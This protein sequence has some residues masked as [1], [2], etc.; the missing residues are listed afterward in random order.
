M[1]NSIWFYII[2]GLA[3]STV[4]LGWLSLHNYTAKVEAESALVIAINANT[5][6]QK[7]LNLKDLSCKI[8]DSIS[9]ERTEEKQASDSVKDKEIASIDKLPVKIKA[10]LVTIPTNQASVQALS[11]EN[12]TV[13]IDNELPADLV[14][15]LSQSYNRAKE[16]T[17]DD[18]RQ[19]SSPSL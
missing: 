9:A 5:D 3:L 14:R 7:S 12:N 15:L 4:S 11:N 2:L 10:P 6:L 16:R 1:F 17:G 8:D 18:S 13:D 19:P